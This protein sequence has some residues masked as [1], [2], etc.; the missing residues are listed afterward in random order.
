MKSSAVTIKEL[1]SL[2][3]FSVSTVSKALNNKLEISKSTR[4]TIKTLAKQ[5]NYVPNSY[6]V[7]LR[8]KKSELIAVIIPEVTQACYSYTLH[9]IQKTAERFGYRILFYQS[10]NSYIKEKEYVRNL[11][12][13]SIDGII[14]VSNGNKSKSEYIFNSTPVELINIQNNHPYDEIEA[15]T[16][17]KMIKLIDVF[18]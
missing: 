5:H 7:S 15:V 2:S 1:S 3:G 14:I 6:A 17:E 8:I 16:N 12:D 13:G 4:E 11:S 18:L 9:C 10:Y